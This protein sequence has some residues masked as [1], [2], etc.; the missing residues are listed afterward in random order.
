VPSL[1]LGSVSHDAI[2]LSD[3]QV[4]QLIISVHLDRVQAI[5]EFGTNALEAIKL[6][7]IGVSVIAH[8]L[9][10]VIETWAYWSMVR[11]P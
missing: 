6:L 2:F 11:V 7:S 5:L 8:I 1:L 3:G 4:N 9:K 10:K